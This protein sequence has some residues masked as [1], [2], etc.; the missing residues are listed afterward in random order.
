MG[1]T[2]RHRHVKASESFGFALAAAFLLSL[3]SAA[4]EESPRPESRNG[5]HA[6]IVDGAPF[7]VL[8]AQANNSSVRADKRPL[9]FDRVEEGPY[10]KGQWVF[11]RRW[12]GDQI[13]YGLN[14][15]GAKQV[16]RVKLA[17]YR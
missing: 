7:L 4:A 11:Q 17:T 14:F 15:T 13:D 3:A 1:G 8:G 10:D 2:S 16:L 6:L 5:H 9:L 12:N